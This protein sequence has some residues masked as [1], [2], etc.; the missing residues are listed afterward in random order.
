MNVADLIKGVQTDLDD[1]DGT[2]FTPDYITGFLRQV[3]KKLANKLRLTDSDF[4]ERIVELPNIQAGTPDLSAFQKTGQP[5]EELLTPRGIEWK[6]PGQDSR[7]YRLADGPLDK[8]RDVPDPGFPR[9]D[10]WAFITQ[11]VRLSKMSVNLDLRL[12][13][14][15]LP[16]P[17]VAPDDQSQLPVSADVP[18]Q[19]MLALRVAEANGRDKTIK[20]LSAELVDELDDVQIAL[21]KGQQGQPRRLGRMNGRFPGRD[22]TIYKQ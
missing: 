18:F 21:V 14:D 17:M 1:P 7:F 8:V 6:L 5:L 3:Y 10:S 11:I 15:F 19:T 13:G 9:L 20:Y 22:L 4:D 16:D 2:Y 12:T